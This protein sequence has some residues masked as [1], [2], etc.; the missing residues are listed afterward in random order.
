M[1]AFSTE[2]ED[3]GMYQLRRRLSEGRNSTAGKAIPVLTIL[4]L[5]IPMLLLGCTETTLDVGRNKESD[6]SDSAHFRTG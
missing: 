6:F 1:R 5:T 4:I 2:G 3:T